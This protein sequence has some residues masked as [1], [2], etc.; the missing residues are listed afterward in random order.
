MHATAWLYLKIMSERTQRK[1]N[2]YSNVPFIENSGKCNLIYRNRKQ[3][4]Q[5]LVG[6]WGG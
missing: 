4:A 5:Q 2:A 6:G 3:L 1:K